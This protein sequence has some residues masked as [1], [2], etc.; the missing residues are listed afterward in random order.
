MQW[1]KKY[2]HYNPSRISERLIE[3]AGKILGF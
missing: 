2:F 1:Q 3:A